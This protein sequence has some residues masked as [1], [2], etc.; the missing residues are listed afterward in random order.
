M[1]SDVT[2]QPPTAPVGAR[3]REGGV[4]YTRGVEGWERNGQLVSATA[5]EV[6]D[7]IYYSQRLLDD[8]VEAGVVELLA[9]EE[10][11]G[12]K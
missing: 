9:R 4:S 1:P 2:M 3:Y 8:L 6:L 7:Q 11:D 10:Q 12:A 5:A